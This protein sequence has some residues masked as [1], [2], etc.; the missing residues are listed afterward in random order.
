MFKCLLF[1]ICAV[2]CGSALIS[3]GRQFN[4]KPVNLAPRDTDTEKVKYIISMATILWNKKNPT[5]AS[6]FKITSVLNAT[7]QLD[8]SGLFNFFVTLT[9]TECLKAD[10]YNWE[11]LEST[12]T[13]NCMLT[14]QSAIC[15]IRVL[16]QPWR[17]AGL[18]ITL[19]K[20]IEAQNDRNAIC[21]LP[22][23]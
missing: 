1:V 19:I 4:F 23:Y 9:R 18:P 6:Y 16:Y 22:S 12:T 7:E 15:P 2:S 13:K 11:S 3:T 21:F 20:P 14:S 8:T 5:L 10:I 17:A